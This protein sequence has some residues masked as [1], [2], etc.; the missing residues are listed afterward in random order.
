MKGLLFL[1]TRA[2][3]G[4]CIGVVF[5]ALAWSGALDSLEDLTVDYRLRLR[6]PQAVSDE[7]RLVGIGDR[8]NEAFGRWPFPRSVHGIML[9]ILNAVGVKHTTFDVVFTEPSPDAGQDALLKHDIEELKHATLA[10]HFEQADAATP[11]PQVE[12]RTHFVTNASRHGLQVKGL[13]WVHGRMPVAPFTK[14]PVSYGAV[15]AVPDADGVIRRVPLFFEHQGRFYPSLAMQTLIDALGLVPE[16]DISIV[17]GVAI[18]L[19]NTPRGTLTI[20]IDEHGQYRINYLGDLD[21]FIPAFEY[22]DLHQAVDSKEMGAQVEAALKDR[23]VLVG[24]VSTGNTDVASTSIGRVPGVAV[25]AT[26]VS[27]ILTG[28]HLRFLAKWQQALLVVLAGTLLGLGMWP[29]RAWLGIVAF[30]VMIAAWSALAVS[31]ANAN[32]IL[33]VVPVFATFSV[34]TLALLGLEAAAMKQD[35][36]RVVS[37]L[38]RYIARPVLERLVHTE[39]TAVTTT[40]RRELTIFFSDI[41]GFTAWT[42]RA[43]PDEVATRLNEYFAAMTP[44]IERHGATLDKF[45]GD[46][47][48]VFFSAPVAQEDHA[49]RAVRMALDMQAAMQNL[50]RTWEARGNAPLQVGMGIHTSFVTVGN[51][52]SS[53]YMHYTVVGPGVHLTARIQSVTP[54]GKVWI[55]AKTQAQINGRVETAPCS[56]LDMKGGAKPMPI[57]EVLVA[58]D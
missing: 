46:C 41:R 25:Q 43:E 57:F 10:Y 54:A 48:M 42:E 2:I 7:V 6:K 28:N 44:I 22:I 49:L 56:Q 39:P 14:L 37:V 17:P 38:G 53:T 5:A 16:D 40:E 52:G 32:V 50:N 36:S 19:V 34:A 30:F 45:I 47:I 51:F 1:K 15:N 20:P 27:N 31:A 8:D 3:L 23:I 58:K 33:P 21:V 9:R 18:T 29:T 12:D 13:R 26:V 4:G 11:A 35:R 55:S 24:V